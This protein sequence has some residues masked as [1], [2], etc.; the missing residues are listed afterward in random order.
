MFT[1]KQVCDQVGISYETLRYYCEEGLI[2]DISRDRN[3]Y[4]LF[5]QKHIEWIKGLKRLR[6]CGFTIK[7]MK[8]YMLLCLE[9]ERSIGERKQMLAN[10]RQKLQHNLKEIKASIQYIDDKQCYYDEIVNG[11]IPFSSNLIRK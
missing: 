9:G 1:M 5:D 4:R 6:A 7:E 8:S 11:T 3:Q 2:L 10:K